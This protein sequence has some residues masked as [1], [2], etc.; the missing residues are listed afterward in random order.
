MSDDWTSVHN[1]LP[2]EKCE[3]FSWSSDVFVCNMDNDPI[4]VDVSSYHH[5]TQ[6]WADNNL[7]T[8]WKFIRLPGGEYYE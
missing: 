4:D 7:Y 8:H 5:P 1:K 3:G 2:E 6:S